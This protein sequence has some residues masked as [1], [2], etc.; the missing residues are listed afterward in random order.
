MCETETLGVLC[1]L[2][3]AVCDTVWCS[4]EKNWNSVPWVFMCETLENVGD[5]NEK[6]SLSLS[7]YTLVEGEQNEKLSLSLS[8]QYTPHIMYSM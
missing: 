6:L 4:L 3:D 2:F 7:Q 1:A 5:W 8:P